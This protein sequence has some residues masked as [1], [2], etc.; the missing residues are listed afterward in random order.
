[1]VEDMQLHGFSARTQE[2]YARAV[3]QLAEHAH[4]APD[5]ISEDELR[6]YFLYLANVRHVAR[7]TATIA[8]CG[9][10]FLFER[11]LHRDWPTLD[12]VRP[13]REEKLPVVLAREEVRQILQAV[14]IPVYRVCLITIYSCGLRLLEGARLQIPDVDSARGVLRIH[15]KGRKDRDVPLPTATLLLLRELWRTHRSP[16]RVF[17]LPG[18]GGRGYNERPDAGP[19]NRCGLQSAFRGALQRSGICKRAHIHTLRHSYAT[20]LLEDGVNLRLIQNYLGHS[21][22]STTAV[23]THLTSV[24]HASAQDPINRLL[25]GF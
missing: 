12:L 7:G 13:P 4:K 10:K 22:P 21:S 2:A 18:P 16:T 1:M 8:L 14:R 19:V 24:A 6:E 25:D 20:H 15:G 11:T 17:P 5:R 9:I 3:R 23:Y